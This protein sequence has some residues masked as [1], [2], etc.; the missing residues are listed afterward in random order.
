MWIHC[1]CVTHVIAERRALVRGDT[2]GIADSSGIMTDFGFGRWC[3][4]S[5]QISCLHGWGG[6]L[7]V[8][9]TELL[10]NDHTTEKLYPDRHAYT[11]QTEVHRQ[12]FFVVLNLFTIQRT[13]NINR[14][15]KALGKRRDSD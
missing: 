12:H 5:T 7:Q 10:A 1:T 3:S 4:V 6:L 8:Q 15:M 13:V 14:F 9:M 2:T 11:L